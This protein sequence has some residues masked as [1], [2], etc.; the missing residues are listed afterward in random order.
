[1]PAD[2]QRARELFLHAVGKL[3][4][5]DWDAYLAEACGPDE[6]LRR[7]V[8]HLLEVHREAGSFLERPAEGV[9]AT[10][11]FTPPP[12]EEAGTRVEE[13]GTLIG[14]Y[15]LAEVIG[16]GGMGTVYL[17]RQTAPVRRLVALKVIKPGLDSKQVLARFEAERQALALMDHPHIARVLDAGA[18][19]AGRPYFVMELVKG[20]PITRYCDEH[21]LTPRERLELFVPVCQAIQHAHQKGVIHRDIKP[22]N[23]L[24]ALYDGRPV[25]KVID[26]GIAKAAGQQLTEHTLMTGFGSVVGTLE[27]MSP[28]QAELNQLDIDTRSDVY[29]LGVLLYELLTGSTPL[30]KKRLKEAA[31][32]EVL[33]VIRE[34]E[35]PRP[36]TRLSATDELPSVAANR[37]LEPKKLSG[38]VRGELDWIVMKALEKDRNRRYETAN[39]FAMDVQRYLADEPVQACPPSA[40][41]RLRKFARRN[42]GWVGTAAL[43]AAVLL[44]A[45]AVSAALAIWAREAEGVARTERSN[46]ENLARTEAAARAQAT[47]RAEDLARRLYIYRVNL[48]HREALADNVARADALLGECDPARRGWEWAYTRR[49]CHLEA[50]TLGG[51]ADHAAAVAGA[52]P[53]PSS[54]V[55]TGDRS[56]DD[57]ASAL[58]PAPG[59]VSSVAYSPDGRRIAAAHEDGT[60]RL[61]DARTGLELRSLVG[62]VGEVSSVAFDTAG[63]RLI[64]GGL[65]RT[66]R[67]WDANSGKPIRVLRGHARPV[68]SVAFRP[69]TDQAASSEHG[70]YETFLGE[71]CVFKLW[72]LASGREVHT[73]HHRHG[74]SYTKVAFSPDGRRLYS[75]ANWGGF[76][77]LWDPETGKEVEERQMPENSGALAVSPTEGRLA[78]GGYT[79][80]YLGG[81]APGWRPL[82]GHGGNVLGL[83]FSPDGTRLASA[84]RDGI[85]KVWRVADGFE[86]AHLR[87][88]TGVVNSVAFGPDGQTLVTGSDDGTAKV[89]HVSLE[90]AP[91]PRGTGTPG[92]F[93]R[94]A[95]DGRR[96]AAASFFYVT[97]FDAASRQPVFQIALPKN[98]AGISGLAYSQDGQ[99]VATCSL[100]ADEIGV[101][102]A[103]TGKPVATFGTHTGGPHAVVFGPGHQLASACTDGTVRLWDADT[104]R[105]GLVFHAHEGPVFHLA[106]DPA[107]TA[108]ATL[109]SDG[110]VRRWDANT[111][112]PLGPIATMVHRP[113]GGRGDALAFDRDG[114]RLAAAGTDGTVCVWDVRTREELFTLRGHTEKVNGVAFSPDGR[115]IATGS[116]DQTIKLWDAANGD[117]MFT[118]RGHTAAVKGF[119]FSP[120]GNVIY[121]TGDDATLRLWDAAPAA[122]GQQMDDAVAEYREAIRLKKDQAIAHNNLGNAMQARGQLDEAIAEFREALGLQKDY[123]DA[124]YNLGNALRDKGRLEEAIAE[125]REAVRIQKD[126]PE[127]H[128]NLGQ[129]LKLQG[130]FRQALEEL[131]RGH[132]LGSR[133][134]AWPYPSAQWVRQCERLVELDG[135]LSGFLERK[136]TPASAA[137]RIEL[138]GLCSLKH[139]DG[140]A[141]R[142][143]EEAF[144]EQPKLAEAL[145]AHRYNAAC[146]AALAGCGQGKDADQLD[147]KEKSRLRGRALAWLRADLEALG[148]LLGNEGDPAPSAAGVGNV[149]RHWQADPDLAGV[150]GA[151]ALARLPKAERQEWQKVWDDVA[152]TLARVQAKIASEKKAGPAGP[153]VQVGQEL[154][155]AGPTVGG[156]RFDLKRLRGKVV[157][158]DFWATW[159]GPCVAEMP[160]VMKVYDRHHKDGFEVVGVSLDNEREALTRF[161][162]AK[163]VPWPQLFFDGK[164]EQGWNNP[165]ARRYGVNAI[166]FTILVDRSGKVAQVGARG[167]VLEPAVTKLLGK[168]PAPPK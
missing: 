63:G 103:E 31:L 122:K 141:A 94:F 33:R 146:A 157:L 50:L 78:L 119:A 17:A 61:Y 3:P 96:F 15:Q 77:R 150:R 117:E 112:R 25:P 30:E 88:H 145:N 154:D 8:Q 104:G 38:L 60:I 102:S 108:L 161:L 34:E 10:G 133:N 19:A 75:A 151:E 2:L 56:A 144:A 140:A 118:L 124:H 80:V 97:V 55:P 135:K 51:F 130:E 114:H 136:A 127:A 12:A 59:A 85:V 40:W 9:G 65:D 35:P 143:Y 74:W 111:G 54:V 47:E 159:C 43:L 76:L 28:E 13:A 68:V 24:V 99:L 128:C 66:V 107:G 42:K 153:G 52:R 21:R 71:G 82:R 162:K 121:S 125:F 22:S 93:V 101:W 67:V 32:L 123:A 36:S 70:P 57:L 166:P 115:R 4:P 6:E 18:T 20:V 120:D 69:G 26:F 116:M 79:D 163:E 168:Q 165:L 1:M 113:S 44:L 132:E 158:I 87:G 160:N 134:P 84:S 110:E 147:A 152:A 41:Y 58:T 126:F 62:H 106:F 89:W 138:A 90:S 83:A 92:F 148:R 49:L 95:P 14:P 5:E 131:R 64:S 86:L 45:T 98:Y 23:V 46:A 91:F 142:F 105:P 39:G 73:L 167:E 72:D 11:A 53:G 29:S 16:E 100:S 137:E 149:L 81:P 109:G 48:G 139:R 129:A 7:H 37:G 155:L 27:Y 164:G 156:E